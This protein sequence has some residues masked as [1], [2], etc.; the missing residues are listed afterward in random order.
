M[1]SSQAVAKQKP[2]PPK[3]PIIPPKPI[4]HILGVPVT[5]GGYFS[6][7]A[8]AEN[9]RALLNLKTPLD[10]RKDLENVSFYPNSEQARGIVFFSIKF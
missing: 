8:K 10:P 5:Y 9:K 6:D 7:I 3:V 4:H 2:P 1:E